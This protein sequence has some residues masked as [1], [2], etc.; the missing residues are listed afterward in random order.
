M[1]NKYF[2]Q[3]GEIKTLTQ[4]LSKNFLQLI[5]KKKTTI[6]N[7]S[8]IKSEVRKNFFEK[9]DNFQFQRC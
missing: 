9:I 6:D 3:I 7:Y 5:N 4:N 8:K 2:R 1:M